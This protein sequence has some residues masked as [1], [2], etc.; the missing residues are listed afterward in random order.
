MIF[1]SGGFGPVEV[2]ISRY[3]H[4]ASFRGAH[5]SSWRAGGGA[6]S[7]RGEA[8]RDEESAL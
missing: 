6:V 3:G 5:R 7:A 4:D 1:I 2:P 8:P